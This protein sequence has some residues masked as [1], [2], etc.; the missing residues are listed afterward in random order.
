ME[1]RS[2]VIGPVTNA[3]SVWDPGSRPFQLNG[4][5]HEARD[6]P[7]R[8]AACYD[9]PMSFVQLQS[10]VAVA[11]EGAVTQAAQKLHITQPPLTRRIRSLEDELGT[12]LFERLP[13]GMALTV[14]GRALLPHARHI[15]AAVDE[16]TEAVREP[17]DPPP[18]A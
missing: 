2:P 14:A 3:L 1:T 9:A 13:R 12:E 6:V 8:D 18:Q 10:F 11:E 4:L 7:P 17:P 15:L 16:A 5:E